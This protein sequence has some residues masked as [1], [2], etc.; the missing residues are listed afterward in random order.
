MITRFI[1]RLIDDE[2]AWDHYIDI[3]AALPETH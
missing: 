2:A 1:Q 3:L